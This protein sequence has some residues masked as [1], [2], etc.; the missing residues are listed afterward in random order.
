[1]KLRMAD[2]D[3]GSLGFS[4]LL[5][6]TNLALPEW[7]VHVCMQFMRIVLQENRTTD[8]TVVTKALPYNFFIKV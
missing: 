8:H 5:I 3:P 6:Q 4:P 2:L 7:F 1:M